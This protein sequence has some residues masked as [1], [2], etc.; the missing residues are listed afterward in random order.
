[1]MHNYPV[2]EKDKETCSS[3]TIWTILKSV[4]LAKMSGALKRR[5]RRRKSRAGSIFYVTVKLTVICWFCW[6]ASPGHWRLCHSFQPLLCIIEETGRLGVSFYR[7]PSKGSS[8]LRILF[9]FVDSTNGKITTT[10]KPCIWLISSI[11]FYMVS[12]IHVG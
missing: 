6:L 8:Y 12:L 5:R 10:K 7:S 9:S 3:I 11:A 4:F 1:M 2:L